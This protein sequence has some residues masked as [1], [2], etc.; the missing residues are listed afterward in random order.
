MM[1]QRDRGVLVRCRRRAAHDAGARGPTDGNHGGF[2]PT[3][4]VMRPG[5]V[6]AVARAERECRWPRIQEIHGARRALHF[7]DRQFVAGE[8]R[9]KGR[10]TEAHRTGDAR[11]YRR[12]DTGRSSNCVRWHHLIDI[13]NGRAKHTIRD[14]SKQI[15][16]LVTRSTARPAAG[17]DPPERCFRMSR[18]AIATATVCAI[19]S[20]DRMKSSG[21]RESADV[22]FKRTGG[23]GRKVYTGLRAGFSLATD[24]SSSD[25]SSASRVDE[26]ASRQTI[27]R[28]WT[29]SSLRKDR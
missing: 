12:R 9:R 16:A 23:R 21:E 17:A 6:D 3:T 2:T 14:L 5:A 18:T 24:T 13:E 20:C 29:L 4:M 27:L 25:C 26:V 19:S 28:Q 22:I 7:N 15:R 1:I 11:G 10:R 8:A